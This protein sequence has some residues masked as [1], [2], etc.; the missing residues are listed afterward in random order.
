MKPAGVLFDLDGTLH[1]RPETLRRYL[2]GHVARF[3]LPDGYAER[4][5]VLDDFGY[6]GKA[7][8]FPMLVAGFRLDHPPETLLQDFHNHAWAD[9]APMPHAHPVLAALR[10]QGLRLGL[11]TNG[12][13]DPQRRCLAGLGLQDAFDMV[14]VSREVGLSKPDPQIYRLALE[15]LGLSAADTLFVGDSPLN[16]AA[17]PQRVGMRAAWLPTSHPLPA[18]IRPD[19][20]LTD[21][22]DVLALC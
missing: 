6:R 20:R 22:R 17:G 13:S 21:L 18:G 9:V 10:A 16:D 7:E 5:V 11:V 1:D 12:W 8:V 15:Q 2:S 3:G 14:I 19:N 4:F